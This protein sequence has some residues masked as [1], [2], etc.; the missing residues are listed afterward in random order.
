M[1]TLFHRLRKEEEGQTLVLAVVS[2]LVLAM[3]L[4][5]TVN[6][7]QATYERIRLQNT[8]D[9]TAY[10]LAATQARVFNFFAYTNRAMIAHYHS[11]LTFMAYLSYALYL[12]RTF[13]RLLDLLSYVPYIGII[14]NIL[15]TIL[16]ILV[17][18]VDYL[19]VV[20]VPALNILN[21]AYFAFQA[22]MAL[23]MNTQLL[24]VPDMLSR[25][26]PDATMDHGLGLIARGANTV[27]VNRTVDWGE[28]W[29]LMPFSSDYKAI[30]GN[31]ARILMSE[32]INSSRHPWVAGVRDGTRII[33]R[34]WSLSFSF[35]LV[36][37][38][39]NVRF[40]KRA[41]T[42]HGMRIGDDGEDKRDQIYAVDALHLRFRVRLGPGGVAGRVT[43]N[44]WYLSE[45]WG[46]LEMGAHKERMRIDLSSSGLGSLVEK[47]VELVV[48]PLEYVI[49]NL[50]GALDNEEHHLYL[51][52]TPYMKFR[53]QALWRAGFGQPEYIV[54]VA[55]END[56]IRGALSD[57][58]DVYAADWVDTELENR[59]GTRGQ[60]DFALPESEGGLM[61]FLAPG[62]NAIAIGRAYYHRPGE[63]KEQPNFFNPFWG[64]KLH[65]VCH[66]RFLNALN[67]SEIN[68]A[69]EW[70]ITH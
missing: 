20:V 61:D 22:G 44:V 65:P 21:I 18:I 56:A 33:G 12:D 10:S 3:C 35:W 67:I 54:A 39:V 28:V 59:R 52:V 15:S 23:V 26:D 27:M 25:N 24:A 58:P 29:K 48:T 11:M 40:N 6:I 32:L 60:V 64:A 63:W 31:Q 57:L 14:A 51:G 34:R 36:V 70:I 4:M 62:F 50:L 41:R 66:Y 37:A 42:E 5:A 38:D 8:A 17:T 45:V 13:G 69:C 1:F 47:L 19:V 7:G 49:N 30:D 2:M 16:E 53:P 43:L 9:A 68:D 46:D 55:K